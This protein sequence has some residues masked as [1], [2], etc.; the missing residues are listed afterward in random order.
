[1]PQISSRL[2]EKTGE[3]TPQILPF[4]LHFFSALHAL[5]TQLMLATG[6]AARVVWHWGRAGFWAALLRPLKSPVSVGDRQWQTCSLSY[7]PTSVRL[8]S[9]Q[10]SL[11]LL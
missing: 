1:M 3:Q 7:K 11:W 4:L 10:V 5:G 9:D 6:V 2:R 8:W